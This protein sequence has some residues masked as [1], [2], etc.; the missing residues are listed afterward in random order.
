MSQ[1]S[2][3]TF[4]LFLFSVIIFSLFHYGDYL[5][6]IASHSSFLD[7]NLYY[8]Y[9]NLVSKGVS[10]FDPGVS[11]TVGGAQAIA[12]YPPLFYILMRPILI[13]PFEQ[14]SIVWL[15]LNQ[16]FILG[17]GFLLL[18]LSSRKLTLAISAALIFIV[19]NFYPLLDN[20]AL[21]QVNIFILFLLSSALFA[22]KKN[23]LLLSAIL[24]ALT[25]HI[26]IQFIFMLPVLFWANYQRL[27]IKSLAFILFGWIISL[28]LV[29]KEQNLQFFNHLLQ[30]PREFFLWQGNLSVT[31][32]VARLFNFPQG[33]SFTIT[34]LLYTLVIIGAL[35]IFPARSLH[36]RGSATWVWS[37]GIIASLILSPLLEIHHLTLTLLPIFLLF[38]SEYKIKR[39]DVI[40]LA[41]CIFIL[42]TY[43]FF[44]SQAGPA[45]GLGK[46]LTILR[47]IALIGLG[48]QVSKILYFLSLPK[49]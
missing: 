31:A 32:N 21:G 36:N 49:K 22:L 33:F 43:A 1:E 10:P 11:V 29:G 6:N 34:A 14:A 15:F 17:S 40:F 41:F 46:L 20:I 16:L 7:F 45:Q 30:L 26:K 2:S 28:I 4:K 39:N 5:L 3:W 38:V 27:A 13:L 48:W 8:I 35:K 24:I 19:T 47:V 44:D 23:K 25:T 12:N 9:T 37:L 42:G 18:Q